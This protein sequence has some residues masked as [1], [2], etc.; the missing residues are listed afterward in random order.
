MESIVICWI[1]DSL[2]FRAK[3]D[4]REIMQKDLWIE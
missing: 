3:K 4:H 1:T 2:Q